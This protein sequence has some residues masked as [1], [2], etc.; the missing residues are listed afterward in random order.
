M[1]V[2]AGIGTAS[3]FV[4][5]EKKKKNRKY[6]KQHAA[7]SSQQGKAKDLHTGWDARAA[8]RTNAYVCTYMLFRTLLKRKRKNPFIIV[9]LSFIVPY[10]C[11]LS[12]HL[13]FVLAEPPLFAK[14]MT[15]LVAADQNGKGLDAVSRYSQQSWLARAEDGKESGNEK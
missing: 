8:A 5:E 11:F 6:K 2:A 1:M 13:L 12:C 10:L 7:C 14:I 9:I 3:V 4:R 15:M